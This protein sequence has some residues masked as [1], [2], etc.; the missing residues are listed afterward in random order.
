MED[1]EEFRV[2]SSRYLGRIAEQ[3]YRD[4]RE[5]INWVFNSEVVEDI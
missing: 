1:L 3:L 4:V 2:Y 5:M